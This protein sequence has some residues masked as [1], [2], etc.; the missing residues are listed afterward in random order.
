MPIVQCR[1]ERGCRVSHRL[2]T[3]HG[4]T[5]HDAGP[6]RL[7]RLDLEFSNGERRRYERLHGRGH[8]AVVVVP[9]LDDD[10]VLL[11]REYAAGVHRYELGLVKGRIDAGETP[12][13]A[14]D[15]ELKEEAGY[16][17][18]SL[19]VLRALT[20]APT[21]M[22]HE[23]HLVVARDLYP[24]R[25][26]GDEPEELEVVPWR[27]DALHELILREDFSEGRS[28]AALFIAREWLRT[29]QK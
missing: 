2:P 12:L 4:I 13:Q 3:I 10:T 15:R 28:I 17:A 16:G 5:E 25:L 19:T 1:H 20:L 6:Y 14:A 11:V 24:E 26:P 7:E 23:A 29:Q 8:G 21:Y 18:R 27:L 9:L 22:S